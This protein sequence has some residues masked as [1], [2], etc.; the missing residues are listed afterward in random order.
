MGWTPAKVVPTSS[1]PDSPPAMTDSSDNITQIYFGALMTA[2][3]DGQTHVVQE[4]LQAGFDVTV[5][6]NI[7]LMYAVMHGRTEI[8]RLLIDAG[9]DAT[10]S[11]RKL[12][13]CAEENGDTEIVRILEG[14]VAVN[15]VQTTTSDVLVT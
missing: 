9:A 14:A 6:N 3:Q 12:V 8:V 15:V 1:H 10:M 13:Q 11:N 4:K 5:S 7:A 2:I